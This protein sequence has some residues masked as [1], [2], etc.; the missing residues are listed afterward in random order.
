MKVHGDYHR[1]GYA[2]VEGLVPL[3]V[4]DA[5]LASI[6]QDLGDRPI[7]LSRMRDFPN[8]L[9]RPA[10][11]IYGHQY[12]PMIFFLWGLTP[13][14][15]EIV[16]RDL[17]PTYDYFRL[18]RGGDQ[19]RVHWDRY[20]CEHSL[21]LTLAYSDGK[22]W[23]LEVGRTRYPEPS[24]RVEEDF[25]DEPYS[26]IAMQPGDGVLYQGVHHRHGR[27]TANPNGWSAHLFLHWVDRD[28]PYREHAMDG[29]VPEK[30]AFS[31][32]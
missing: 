27:V 18:Y 10:L 16:G 21:S 5:F 2:H 26:S 11:E 29:N 14:V 24:S 32:A 15:R 25:G 30:V 7:P 19:C 3:D 28:G 12:K 20:S 22:P 4:A 1:D 6:K 31:F 23:S 8:L 9:K 13:I 17:V